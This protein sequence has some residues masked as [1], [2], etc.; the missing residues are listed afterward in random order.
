M[1]YNS[2]HDLRSRQAP[3]RAWPVAFAPIVDKFEGRLRQAG[4]STKRIA[5]P[6]DVSELR[7]N[8]NQDAGHFNRDISALAASQGVDAV[9]LIG[10]DRWYA[11]PIRRLHSLG[12]PKA[13]VQVSGRLIARDGTLRWQIAASEEEATRPVPVTRTRPPFPE[14]HARGGGRREKGSCISGAELFGLAQSL[15]P[16]PPPTLSSV[17]APG[18]QPAAAANAAPAP[19]PPPPPG[20]PAEAKSNKPIPP[21]PPTVFTMWILSPQPSC[22]RG[23]GRRAETVPHP[24]MVSGAGP[25]SRGGRAGD[26]LCI[27]LRTES[28]AVRCAEAV[29]PGHPCDCR[30]PRWVAGFVG[31]RKQPLRAT[32]RVTSRRAVLTGRALGGTLVAAGGGRL[33][34]ARGR[35]HRLERR[36]GQRLARLD[37]VSA[38]SCSPSG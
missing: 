1:A 13:L 16:P 14:R 30:R 27:E 3:D 12:D 20:A 8:P 33:H 17:M 38:P 19:A 23:R 35:R 36:G 25:D 22:A 37:Q 28:R 29:R 21:T 4:F 18:V 2:W 32:D 26:V 31:R 11:P 24:A 15:P 6:I 10:L 9:L 34:R 7:E 5:R